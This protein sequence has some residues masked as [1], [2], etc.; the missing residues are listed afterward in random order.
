MKFLEILK[1][2]E[3]LKKEF[4]NIE[5]IEFIVLSNISVNQFSPILEFELRSSGVNAS[6]RIGDYDNLLQI[7]EKIDNELPIIF[8]E[9]SNLKESFVYEIE[10]YSEEEI[11]NFIDKTIQ[12]LL[13][14]F[15]NLKNSKQVYFNKFSHLVFSNSILKKSNFENFVTK[16]N[17]FLNDNL[18]NNFLIIDIDKVIARLGI[19]R[20]INFRNFYQ[21]KSFYRIEFFETYSSFIAP[22][23]LSLLGRSKKALIFD[24]DNT[25]WNGIVGEDGLDGIELSDT[26]RKGIFFKEVQMIAKALSKR[27]VILGICS[28]NNENDVNDVFLFRKD[29]QLLSSE[30]VI[31]KINWENKSKNI[32]LI[33]TEL[34]I[35]LDSI[36]FIDDSSFEIEMIKNNLPSIRT[37]QVPAD[38]S[39]YPNNLIEISNLFYTSSILCEDVERTK[40]YKQN[41]ERLDTKAKFNNLEEYI[42]SLEIKLEIS[43]KSLNSI[44]RIAQLTQKTNQFNLT[45]IRYST[46]DIIR[47]F[48]LDNYD[49]ISINVSD[50]FGDS[51][52]TGVCIIEYFE[53]I[54]V[55]ESFLMSCR[56]LGR[57][58]ENVFLFEI[59]KYI[60]KKEKLNVISYYNKTNK[61]FQTECFFEKNNFMI[62]DNQE[63]F[64]KYMIYLSENILSINHFNYI[65][66]IWKK[67]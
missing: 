48:D 64:K 20:V 40:M 11:Q 14:L 44:E 45:N 51:G 9:L 10:L 29:M 34:N 55:I 8:W 49:I 19:N 12:E 47:L 5:K 35:G 46:N 33:A 65:S 43:N 23:I 6:V 50:K 27:G 26:S 41:I 21:S 30:I 54:A 67:E 42:A 56:I 39:T 3:V 60:Y 58:I 37:M 1:Q 18:P 63:S 22:S 17:N 4:S 7:S 62:L 16:I 25:L 2:N 61:N 53:E 52:L 24:C 32:A 15:K 57:N 59:L 13:M 66:T 31:K 38:L 36:V 28:K